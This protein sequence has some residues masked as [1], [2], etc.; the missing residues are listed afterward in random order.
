VTNSIFQ[1]GDIEDPPANAARIYQRLWTN[2]VVKSNIFR[3]SLQGVYL[4]TVR[5]SSSFSHVARAA[6]E[7]NCFIGSGKATA[8]LENSFGVKVNGVEAASDVFT[9]QQNR[10]QYLNRAVHV[11]QILGPVVKD[12]GFEDNTNVIVIRQVAAGD[13][14]ITPNSLNDG[15]WMCATAS[16]YIGLCFRSASAW[17]VRKSET[18]AASVVSEGGF[19]QVTMK[20]IAFGMDNMAVKKSDCSGTDLEEGSFVSNIVLT[21]EVGTNGD[22]FK[23]VQATLDIS[24]STLENNVCK[25][26]CTLLIR[27]R[28]L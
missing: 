10:F 26:K 18:I 27:S 17:V 6:I 9:V 14:V 4:S 5:K 15:E 2:L 13:G 8:V 1:Y 3:H 20:F 28:V 24:N 23:N 25:I 12:N 22:R 19:F 21:V 16:D 7:D 11:V